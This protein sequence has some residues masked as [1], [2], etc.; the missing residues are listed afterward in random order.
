MTRG[1]M[2]GAMAGMVAGLGLA[3][4]WLAP[5]SRNGHALMADTRPLL[6]NG[7]D[8]RELSLP[9]HKGISKT[10]RYKLE[11]PPGAARILQVREEDGREIVVVRAGVVPG[12][13][14]VVAADANGPGTAAEL[15][16][17]PDWRDTDG[18]GFPDSLQ[19][20][21]PGDAQAFRDWF[22]F[23]A[24]EQY[25][26]G[27]DL[28]PEINDCAALLRYAYREALRRHDG[29]WAMRAGLRA[30]KPMPDV[31]RF[32]YP[33]TPLRADLFRLAPGEFRVEDLENGV[34]GQFADAET[35]LLY[36]ASA[37]GKDIGQARPGDL[38]FYRQQNPTMPFHAMIY[39][40][41]S[42]VEQGAQTDY[43]LYHTGPDHGWKGEMR[44]PSL[45]ELFR[46]PEPRWH[47]SAAN[48]AFLGVYRWKILGQPGM[49]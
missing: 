1:K 17:L 36:N 11:G 19:L 44:R 41:P 2:Y 32:Q 23:L 15:E 26:R 6:A 5:T 30:V 24:E 8:Q 16:V 29:A 4:A 45:A 37:I 7:L 40:G 12:K 46:H 35:L 39:L 48:P 20:S 21:T 10:D 14:H 33:F 31:A 43:V 27:E 28:A 9:G 34:F 3:S 47:P 18:D 13:V 42:T 25:Y 22:R 38:L 49:N